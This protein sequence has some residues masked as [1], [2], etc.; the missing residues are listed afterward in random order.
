MKSLNL[1]ICVMFVTAI[2]TICSAQIVT[3]PLPYA[4]IANPLPDTM[5]Q[6]YRD[7]VNLKI[8]RVRVNQAGYRPEDQK[9]FYYVASVAPSGFTVINT[10]TKQV[11]GTGTLT[12]TGLTTAGKFHI[13]ASNN[14]QLV[15]NGDTRYTMD[16][17]EVKGNIY[18]G[19]INLTVPGTYKIIVGSDTSAKFVINDQIYSWI[20]DALLKFYG[21]NRCGDSKSWFH[22]ACH[23][24]DQ[25]TGGWH[26]C[27]DHLKEGITQGYA[28][29]VLGLCAAVFQDR[30]DD[31]Y[32]ANQ[33]QTLITDGIPDILYEAKH[34]TDYILQSYDKASGQ[35]AKMITSI[36]NIGND[37]NWWER[38]EYQDKAPT[39]RGGPVREARNEV[40]ANLLGDFAADLAFV[41]K[42]YKIYD[43]AYSNRC[44]RAAR[45]LYDYAKANQVEAFSPAYHGSG[46]TNDETAFA[47]MALIW[48]TGERKYLDD[49]CFDKTIGAGANT[50]FWA[51]FEGGWFANKNPSLDHGPSANTDWGSSHAYVLWG[52]Y[53]LI[54]ENPQL[55]INLG[56]NE[57]DRLKLVEK[58]AA[59]LICNVSLSGLGN[60]IINLPSVN[61]LFAATPSV[62]FDLPWFTMFTQQ[63]WVWNRYQAGNITELY[64]YYDIASRQQG[65]PLPNIPATTD[66]KASDVKKILVRQLD[67]MLGVNP[68]DIS[69]IYG[70]GSK[71]FNHPHHR[72]ANP[73]GKNVPGAF[74]RYAPPVGAL[75]GGYN[76]K[77]SL[78][79]E[80][81]AV[82]EHS[83]TGIDG[84]TNILVPVVGLSKKLVISAPS[85]NVSVIYAGCDKAI[86]EIRQTK[87]GAATINYWVNGSNQ[88]LHKQSDSAG[89]LHR[90]TLTGLTN[91]TQ[92]NFNVNVKDLAGRDSLIRNINEDKNPVDFTFNTLQNCPTNAQ[93]ANIKICSVTSDSAEIFW[94]TPNGAFESKVVYGD[95]IPPTI[96]QDGDISGHP[97]KFHTVKIGGLKEKTKYYFY[98][99]SG[100][101]KD[102]NNGAYY[103]F[104]TPVQF[105]NFDVRAGR[106]K[107]S[108]MDAVSVDIV[109]Q[110]EKTYDSLDLR[111]YFRSK[112]GFENDLLM[113]MD[114]G[115]VYKADG[116]Q[117]T[118]SQAVKTTIKNQRPVRMDETFNPADST[119]YYYLSVPLWSSQMQSGSRIRLDL[120]IDSRSPYPPYEDPMNKPPKHIID[121]LDWS[122][123]PH[124]KI[125]GD[126]VDFPGI[127]VAPKDDAD[128]NYWNWP[129]DQYV[130]VYRKGQFIW[131]YSP[132]SREQQTKHTDYKLTSQI[133]SPLNNPTSDYVFIE[134]PARSVTV[135]GY[136]TVTPS[137]GTINDIWVNGVRL[138][139]LSSVV[140]WN[141]TLQR[142]DLSIPVPVK[143]GSNPVEIAIFAGPSACD[144]CFGCDNSVH[145]FNIEHIGAKL[146]PSILS[147]KDGS[148]NPIGDTVKIDTSVFNIVVNHKSTEYSKSQKDTISVTISDTLTGDTKTVKLVETGDSSNVFQ[149]LSPVKIVKQSS[150]VNQISMFPADKITVTYKDP[151]DSTDISQA[152]LYSKATYPLALK[153]WLKDLDG[154]GAADHITV[155]YNSNITKL[156][157]SIIVEFPNKTTIQTVRSSKDSFL[158]N[159]TE[160]SAKFNPPITQYVTS[161]TQGSR[162]NGKSYMTVDGLGNI[163]TGFQV[164]DSIGPV[165][166]GTAYMYEKIGDGNDTLTFTFSENVPVQTLLDT[167]L[168]LR[169]SG[170]ESTLRVIN[171]ISYDAATSMVTVVIQKGNAT[172]SDGD[173]LRINP[174]G[175][176]T[177]LF[178]NRVSP[179][180]R[181]IPITQ[182]VSSP[183][184][185]SA[186]YFDKDCDG[187]IDLV[188][189]TFFKKIDKAKLS[190]GF[191]W[192]GQ[193]RL[194]I[195]PG[196]VSYTDETQTR[197]VLNVKGLIENGIITTG[198]IMK[199]SALYSD[200][201]TDS[202]RANVQD[203]AAPVIIYA[204]FKPSGSLTNQVD[205]L[206]VKFS[207]SIQSIIPGTH[208]RFLRT[209]SSKEYSMNL[210]QY[211]MVDSTLLV[212]AG[213]VVGI[214]FPGEKDSIKIKADSSVYDISGNIQLNTENPWAPLRV[215]PMP[216]TVKTSCGP[217][218]FSPD[219]SIVPN[220]FQLPASLRNKRGT[221]IKVEPVARLISKIDMT[222][223]VYIYDAVGNLISSGNLV[224]QENGYNVYFLWDGKNRDKRKVGMGTYVAIVKVTDNSTGKTTVN[225]LSIGVIR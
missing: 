64:M 142:Y 11:A 150:G 222:G 118:M 211:K 33:G 156:P 5:D 171:I 224:R 94:Y 113:R 25:I 188:D 27:G 198:G 89:I 214:S 48:A 158:V 175:P 125:K 120:V 141:K 147:L 87:Y 43:S 57:T 221:I 62:K 78:Y 109:N 200:F 184:I 177:D 218:P 132:S 208:F 20:R 146:Y 88:I 46:T 16:S 154:D 205:T 170:I 130:T 123:G 225:R 8:S 69:M 144:S 28:A 172:I 85:A 53:R 77:T 117:D 96:V 212:F 2:M 30:D 22:P 138:T 90:I 107:W 3:D 183:K 201:P 95:K 133:T 209:D 1:C 168:T 67:Y 80:Y 63:E 182:K 220:Q 31:I 137:D 66:W 202:M 135:K 196:S 213:D 35:V 181:G 173:T 92:Y 128:K 105:V 47:A 4:P 204:D 102:D 15:N 81:W 24:K 193:P 32:N 14:A 26:D 83:E 56:L 103:T 55:C 187:R 44:L 42:L 54:L 207:E 84:T 216:F 23:L 29:A 189:I 124:S 82:Y 100:D 148:W 163:P 180:N 203:Q 192:N 114:I 169:K 59:S 197:L 74:Y 61:V 39:E 19:L 76:P 10:E 134:S 9:Y 60:Q 219:T 18:E 151:L 70:V 51:S 210:K 167:S 104:T 79:D 98:V 145:E 127:P 162:G 152:N 49:L 215:K 186:S 199:I 160:I 72:A 50:Y 58:T 176:L 165:L 126:P 191:T 161:F 179:Q 143:D 86:I 121:S 129:V 108:D 155:T 185:S 12:A 93:V 164:Y 110:E 190:I 73:E 106:Y 119:Y 45:D 101:T 140:T 195:N 36:G 116:F 136:A 41:S 6:L 206:G 217:N 157:D 52:F 166:K 68:W 153:G 115:I 194:A 131:G 21:I 37:H 13:K 139:N 7:S 149:T 159:T 174:L 112:T 75:Q 99:Q 71:N 223:F 91:G 17:P 111:F 122:W 97:S 40:G 178:G 65:S 38:P 34:G